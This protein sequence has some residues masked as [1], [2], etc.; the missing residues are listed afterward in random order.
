MLELEYK[1]LCLSLIS[2]NR[3]ILSTSIKIAGM[4]LQ[5]R[6][7]KLRHVYSI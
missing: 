2:A 3:L 7:K 4:I 5:I 1:W 6:D